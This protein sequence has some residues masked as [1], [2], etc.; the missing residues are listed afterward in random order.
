VIS[1][2]RY[3]ESSPKESLAAFAKAYRSALNAISNSTSQICPPTGNEIARELTV[4]GKELEESLSAGKIEEV[5]A[6]VEQQ[7]SA[8][9]RQTIHY[10]KSKATEVKEIMIVMARAAESLTERDERYSNQFGDLTKRLQ[11]IADLDDLTAMRQSILKSA[12]EITACVS[13]MKED[14]SGSITKLKAELATYQER[15]DNAERLASLDPLT[16]LG[17]RRLLESEIDRRIEQDY[18]FSVMM[19]DLN[20]FKEVNDTYGHLAGDQLLKDFASE[21][22][23][24]F[25]PSDIVGRWG[26]DEFMVVVDCSAEKTQAFAQRIT[27]WVFGDYALADDRKIAMSAAIGIAEWVPETSKDELIAAADR[28]MYEQ[29]IRRRQ[30]SKS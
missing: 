12:Q 26:G 5:Q 17:N 6:R 4:A 14:G 20:G 9:T 22:K 30:Q 18:C 25:R 16:G 8:W 3:L 13:K 1:I 28:A 23:A 24:V 29:K 10:F 27:E 21:L 7:M 11:A 19:L 2:K 15:F